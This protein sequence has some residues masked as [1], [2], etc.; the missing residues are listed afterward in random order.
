MQD[1]WIGKPFR[2]KSRP[3]NRKS[4]KRKM[5]H[6]NKTTS[7]KSK[8]V[9]N[10]KKLGLERTMS[11]LGKPIRKESSP[12]NRKNSKYQREIAASEQTTT[13]ENLKFG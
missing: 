1:E 9:S 11:G 13:S 7:E 6:V 2:K 8:F 5:P 10:K 4:G 3:K 12:K